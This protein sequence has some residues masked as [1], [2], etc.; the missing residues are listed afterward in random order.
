M[1]YYTAMNLNELELKMLIWISQIILIENKI[2]MQQYETKTTEKAQ[3]R[4][5]DHKPGSGN[6]K[7]L[8]EQ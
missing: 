4:V 1:E 3:N 5:V 6:S 8:E 2:P 7:S